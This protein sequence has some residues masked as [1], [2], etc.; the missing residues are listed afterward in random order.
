MGVKQVLLVLLGC[1]SLAAGAVAAVV[2]LLPSFP[3]LLLSALCFARS[4]KRIS[5]WFTSTGLYKNN[6]ETY[7]KGQGLTKGPKIRLM[8]TVT[9]LM[10][11]GFVLMGQILW[12]RILLALIWLFHILYFAFGIKTIQQEK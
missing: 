6:V 12:A 7:L 1:L 9:L 11:T 2:P 10:T 4:S 8:V 5:R 3:F